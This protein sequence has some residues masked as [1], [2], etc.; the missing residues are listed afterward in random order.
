MNVRPV[1]IWGAGKIGRGFLAEVFSQPGYSLTFVDM[2]RPLIEQLSQADGY[3]IWK[4]TN[5][6]VSSKRIEA[7]DA[8]HI[9]DGEA[10]LQKMRGKNPIVSA[11]VQASMLDSLAD[12]LAPYIR[13][14]ASEV[15]DEAMDIVLSVNSMMPDQAF[16]AALE[17]TFAGEENVLDY[18]HSKVGLSVTVVMRIVPQAPKEYAEKDPL[19]VFTNGFPELVAD[20]KG[21]KGP[22]PILPMLRLT[23]HIEAE[24]VRKIY[25]LNMVHATS[26]YLGLPR[27]Y[28]YVKEA[29]ADPQLKPLLRQALNESAI[30][31]SGEYGFSKEDMAAWTDRMMGLIENPYMWDDLLRL[32]AD[33]LRKLGP[34]D[35]LVGAAKLSLKH[36]GKPETIAKAIRMG[37]LYEN[38]DEGTQRVR[39]V[40]QQKG[41]AG[42]LQEISG[43][44]SDEPLYQMVLK[45]E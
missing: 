38:A 14:R 43:L 45:W 42:A 26:A 8:L 25:T 23:D 9:D 11:A 24:E 5:E 3:T 4:A 37:F 40:Y 10:I 1:I 17:R 7:Y 27:R 33:S 36:G 28:T 19:G 12:M 22:L 39:R 35:R 32:G 15:P 34:D 20:K 31:L 30:G 13:A 16:F 2:V 44:S 6:G 29:A 21:F 41:L 18:V